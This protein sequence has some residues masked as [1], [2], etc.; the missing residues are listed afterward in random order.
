MASTASKRSANGVKISIGEDGGSG[1][2][3]SVAYG[4]VWRASKIIG[5]N[6][7]GGSISGS[8]GESA[9]AA[10]AAAMAGC[11]HGVAMAFAALRILCCGW[12]SATYA[13]GIALSV[14]AQHIAA[15]SRLSP[16]A[17]ALRRI[18]QSRGMARAAHFRR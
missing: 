18:A 16:C 10:M 8:N 2:E 11:H 13:R 1:G 7:H 14:S 4:G 12:R 6:G 3:I 17:R 5:S 9:G 15:L